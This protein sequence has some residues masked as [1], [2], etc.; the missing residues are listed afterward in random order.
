MQVRING[1]PYDVPR[2]VSTLED[3]LICMKLRKGNTLL[4][5]NG[6]AVPRDMWPEVTVREDDL[7][8]MLI[9]S[10]GG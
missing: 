10:S 4:K 2:K 7:I 6:H 9:L 3:L 8:E 1:K 5:R